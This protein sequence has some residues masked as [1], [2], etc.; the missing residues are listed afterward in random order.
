MEYLGGGDLMTLLIRKNI[1]SEA[2]AKF[3][4]AECVLAVDSIHKMNFIHRDLKPD[5]I[6]IDNRGH[7]AEINPPSEILSKLEEDARHKRRIEERNEIR[8]NRKLAFSTVGTPDYIAPEV[9]SRTGYS[10]IVD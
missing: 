9:F 2:E 5:N 6:L 10:E 7:N 3:Y 8:K 1:L 4:I